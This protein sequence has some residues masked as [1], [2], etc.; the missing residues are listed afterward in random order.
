MYANNETGTVQPVKEIGNV[1]KKHG[2]LFHCDAVQAVG[3]I[4]IDLSKLNID[5]LSIAAHK[6][7]GPK[8][9]GA[10]IVSENAPVYPLILGGSQE[11][12]RRAGTENV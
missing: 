5:Y 1:C 6:F 2:V 11:N 10:L 9:V 3:H 8:G 7:N 4:R 12:A